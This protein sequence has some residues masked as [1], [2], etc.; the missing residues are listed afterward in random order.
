MKRLFLTITALLMFVATM[1]AG[2]KLTLPDITSGKFAAKTVNGINPIEGTDTYARISQDGERVVCCSFKTGKELSV[3]F[4]VKN[5]MGCKID[6]FD[7]Y[8]L[9]PD[10]KRMLIQTKTE[11]IY[12][13][14]FKAD[15]YIY[16]IESRRL[17]RL[18]DGDK[19]QIPT[20][21]PDGQQVAFVRGGNIF[22]V[23]L[24]YDNAE[25]Q[26]TKDGKFNEVINGLPDWVNE[27]EFGF[28]SALTFNADGTMICWLRYD[29]SKVKT[30]SLEMYKG[31]KP[32][33]EEYDTYPGL[34]SYKYPK[35]GEDNSTVS[36]WSYDIK[37]HKIN[38]LQ[39]P[40]DADGYM[41]R[42]KPTNDPMRIVVYTMNRH[43]D[44]LCLYAVNPRST[45]A[46]LIIKEHVDK[47]VREEAME[48]VKFVGDKI[49]LPSDRSGYTKLYI[50]NMNG[51]LQRTIGDGNYDITSVYGYDP[52]TGDVYYQ[53]AALG[54]TD[55]QVYVTHK[56][57]KT[58]RLT[59]REGWNTA[60]F[61]GDFQY[62]VNTWSDYNTP[63]VFTTR[64]RDGK[65]I[66][67]I[68]DNKAVKQLVSDYGFC[69]REPFSFTTSEGVVL[70]GWMVKP[71]DFDAN[72]KYP[73]IMHQYSGPGSQQ[74]TN[75]W[76][77]GS[78]GQ[79]GAFDSYLAQEGF[80][81]VSVDGR[82]TG[83]RGS[84][85][86]K[87]TYLNLGNLE[88]KD[89]VETALYVGS[90]PYVDKD[91]IGIWGWSY[92]GFNT[93]MSMSEGRGVFRAGVAIAPPTN[94]KYYDS[95]YTERYMRTPKENPD[96]YATNPI[97][98]ASKL[99]G[100]LLICHGT[101]DDNV[102]PQNTYE[103]SEA[104]VQ[105][106]KDFRELFYTNRNHSIFGGN[107]R[108]HLL[109]QVA[110]FFKTELK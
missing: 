36:A 19:Q 17:D 109:R 49:L 89:Q 74:V 13:R 97:E 46:Q 3:L 84:E 14:S 76:S 108:N 10:G 63:Y 29:E 41:P 90:L 87:C 81:V 65:V 88:S 26:V 98:R 53:A 38:R 77:A 92:G 99:H 82:G 25:I 34:Y 51:Q 20:W 95:V 57:G 12:R 83:G 45:V 22:L 79:G 16:N 37:S 39:V 61:S 106:D 21:S 78:M 91:R 27:E 2:G 100:A 40:L 62:F 72:K 47:Y 52:K 48:G 94:W 56:N 1:S 33:K 31:M 44:D 23:K 18:S 107:T 103:Y 105:A 7:D 110:Q 75:S 70:N 69:K 85:F 28:N 86:E 67:T 50:Y 101:A 104:L 96:G 4:D 55:R 59:D 8:V 43:Q 54:A 102:H 30:Y 11:R 64:T 6:G 15:F 42:I 71:K 66:N 58:V 80:I 24:L 60:F 93:L 9:S 73:V 68:E 35:A 32:A 5:T